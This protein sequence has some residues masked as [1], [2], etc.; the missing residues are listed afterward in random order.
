MT[1]VEVGNLPLLYESVKDMALDFK[2]FAIPA[3][4]MGEDTEMIEETKSERKTT[5]KP[6]TY[7]NKGVVIRNK[8]ALL[9][10]EEIDL[11]EIDEEERI[12]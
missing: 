11:Y 2:L 10:E 1:K 3:R 7:S 12:R 4:K 9:E 5:E 6:Y 8:H